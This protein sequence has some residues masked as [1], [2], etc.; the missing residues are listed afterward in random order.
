MLREGSL[1]RTRTVQTQIRQM[2]G[3]GEAAIVGTSLW[4]PAAKAGL[5]NRMTGDAVD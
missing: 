1:E 2:N 4:A 3:G 5:A